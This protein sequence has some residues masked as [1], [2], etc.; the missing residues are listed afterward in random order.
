[1][2][3]LLVLDDLE[4]LFFRLRFDRCLNTCYDDFNISTI[5]R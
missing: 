5:C 3:T 2:V 1:M 4:I